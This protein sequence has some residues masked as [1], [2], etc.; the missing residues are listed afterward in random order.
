MENDSLIST[1]KDIKYLFNINSFEEYIEKI[2]FYATIKPDEIRLYR[3]HREFDWE[4]LPKILRTEHRKTEGVI[5]TENKLLKEF[6]KIGCYTEKILNK[7]P[8]SWDD[9][10]LA[11]HHGL[12]TRLLDWSTN[13]LVALWFAFQEELNNTGF[14]VV[15]G[16]VPENYLFVDEE[17]TPFDQTAT[18]I[19]RPN[20]ITSRITNQ[21]GW[22]TVHKISEMGDISEALENDSEHISTLAK[23][24]LPNN[25]RSN[26]LKILDTLGVNQYSLFQDLEGLSKYLEWKHLIRK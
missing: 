2:A 26:I 19:Y 15:W 8:I 3:G 25:L 7:A 24:I 16:I 10:S 11:Q 18:K 23:F 13:P 4:L 17:K 12:P 22:F 20:H 5:Q 9:I 14:R 6:K 21:N 1:E